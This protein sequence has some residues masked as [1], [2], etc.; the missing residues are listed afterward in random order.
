VQSDISADVQLDGETAT[1]AVDAYDNGG[2][3]INNLTLNANVIAPDGTAQSVEMVQVAPGRYEANFT[4]DQQGAYLIRVSGT[5]GA[6]VSIGETAGWVLSYSPEYK[7]PDNPDVGVNELTQLAL[8]TETCAPDEANFLNLEDCFLAE[9][10]DAFTHDQLARNVTSPVWPYLLLLATLL[11]PFDIAVRR[12]VISRYD[13]QR[14]ATRVQTFVVGLRKPQLEPERVE[15]LNRLRE[16]KGRAGQPVVESD[17]QAVETALSALRNRKQ[18]V[19]PSTIGTKPLDPS[20]VTQPPT[21]P[22]PSP[23]AK[24]T[25]PATAKPEPPLAPEGDST[26]AALLAKKRKRQ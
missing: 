24:P 9:P 2:N 6:N 25:P 19:S 7:L 18:P 23:E 4:P 13:L 22:S 17:A 11:L 15:S 10:K 20:K 16:A 14:V 21:A 26:A 1:L 8:I 12:L 3:F 5:E